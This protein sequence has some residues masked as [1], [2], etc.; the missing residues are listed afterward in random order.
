[1]TPTNNPNWTPQDDLEWLAFQ[2]VSA[3]MAVDESEAFEVRLADDQSAREAV[4]R[5]VQM[6]HAV[7]A[8]AGADSVV[9]PVSAG[10]AGRRVFTWAASLALI[11]MVIVAFFAGSWFGGEKSNSDTLAD[12][13]SNGMTPAPKDVDSKSDANLV[14]AWVNSTE[15]D[16]DN[17]PIGGFPRFEETASAAPT[18]T[19]T[20]HVVEGKFDWVLAALDDDTAKPSVVDEPKGQN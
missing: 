1:M 6:T 3:E 13:N 5:C 8:V 17:E 18:F 9:R 10:F 15:A 14:L 20:E 4:A 12:T 19:E 7:V 2:Y 11:V 16:A